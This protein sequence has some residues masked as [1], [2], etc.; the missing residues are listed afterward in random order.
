MTQP[1]KLL[2]PDVEAQV[3]E[4]FQ[5]EL[6]HP[7]HIVF[8]TG[9]ASCMYCDLAQQL[10]EELVAL[11]DRLSLRVLHVDKDKEQAEAY[12]VEG[13]PATLILAKDEHGHLQDY[14]I[15]FYGL[16]AEHEFAALLHT[17]FSVSKREPAL[18]EA[19][20]RFLAEL[21]QPVRLDVFVTP[22]CPY[23]PNMVFM[24]HQ[25][26]LASSMVRS[27]MVE[28]IE[29]PEWANAYG[30]HGVPHTVINKGAGEIVGMV[31]EGYLVEE[32]RRA[33]SATAS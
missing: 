17:I 14:G 31:P 26:A 9:D 33:L 8:F 15:R 5:K 20:K 10:L 12:G 1:Q 3:R 11:D 18:S 29:F 4:L 22:S 25:M 6:R 24:A 2:G 19:T 30:V 13:V 7:V 23:C 27:N 21:K 28:A 32:I 16:P